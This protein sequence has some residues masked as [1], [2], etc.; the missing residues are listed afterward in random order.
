MYKNAPRYP[1]LKSNKFGK[2]AIIFPLK[3]TFMK[4][5]LPVT[6]KLFLYIFFQ[7]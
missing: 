4:I 2:G 5:F 1:N 3:V 6:H 7:I